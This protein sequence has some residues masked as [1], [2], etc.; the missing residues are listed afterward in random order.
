MTTVIIVGIPGSGLFHTVFFHC[1]LL[2]AHYLSLCHFT[3]HP[4]NYFVSFITTISA[5]QGMLSECQ[6]LFIHS[7][8]IAGS[9]NFI[10]K[11]MKFAHIFWIEIRHKYLSCEVTNYADIWS[12]L[13][14]H[15]MNKNSV[16]FHKIWSIGSELW[17]N[18]ISY[19]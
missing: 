15:E 19:V 5:P 6:S 13:H 18:R 16:T 14:N 10:I 11:H 2:T 7:K 17:K 12:Q 3:S 9:A 1:T 4:S 8:I